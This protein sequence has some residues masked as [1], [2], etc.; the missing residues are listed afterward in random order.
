MEYGVV[1]FGGYISRGD[2]I[3]ALLQDR[4]V[5]RLISAPHGFGKSLLAHEYAQRVFAD[6]RVYWVDARSPE[7]LQELDK[8]KLYISTKTFDDDNASSTNTKGSAKA[9]SNNKKLNNKKVNSK[10][11]K[12]NSKQAENAEVKTGPGSLVIIDDIPYLDEARTQTLSDCIDA[13]LYEHTEVIVTT[14]PSHDV[15]RSAQSDRLLF[16]GQDLLI[17]EEECNAQ[18]PAHTPE[19]QMLRVKLWQQANESFLGRVPSVYF[20]TKE[21]EDQAQRCLQGFFEEK[22]PANILRSA[23]AMLILQKGKNEDLACIGAELSEEESEL[24]DD[25]YAFLGINMMQHSFDILDFPLSRLRECIDSARISDDLLSTEDTMIPKILTLLM[26][27]EEIERAG[28]ILDIFYA[29][30]QCAAW[31][32]EE[33]W[34]LLDR[35]EYILVEKLFERCP[36]K[37]FMHNLLLW[38]MRSWSAGLLGDFREA[39]FYA[40]RVLQTGTDGTL[41][42]STI[43]QIF[44]NLEQGNNT[45]KKINI[46]STED[47]DPTTVENRFAILCSYLA[48]VVFDQGGCA[49]CSKDKYG[50]DSTLTSAADFFACI[51]DTCTEDEIQLAFC[52]DKAKAKEREILIKQKKPMDEDRFRIFETLIN[53]G[54]QR[55]AS[56]LWFRLALHFLHSTNSARARVLLQD[57]A[58]LLVAKMRRKG[59]SRFSEA[60]LLCDLWECN[61]FGP[62]GM[63]AAH[64]D[65]VLLEEACRI[66]KKTGETMGVRALPVPWKPILAGNEIDAINDLSISPENVAPLSVRFFG[67]FE[68]AIGD[69]ILKD[70]TLRRKPRLLFTLIALRMGRDITR[71]EILEELWPG[72]DKVHAMD[73]FY[74]AWSCMNR[75]LNRGPYIT[76]EGEFCRMNQRFVKSDIAEFDRLT[77]TLLVSNPSKAELIDLYSQV[78]TIYSS[79]LL[80][81]E[82]TQP[83]IIQQQEYYRRLFVDTMIAGSQKAAELYDMRLSLWF[84]RQAHEHDPYNESVYY[85]LIRAEMEV[86]QRS[87]AIRTYEECRDYLR[88]SLGISPS[89][90]L[91]HLYDQLIMADPAMTAYQSNAYR[92]REAAV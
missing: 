3:S 24:L 79:G 14:I 40:R 25:D 49:I 64:R 65:A 42:S 57:C 44:N 46:P 23:F 72:F 22:L 50:V 34:D 87:S 36:R 86:G 81:T 37:I 58:C 31:L 47:L 6:G 35:G 18:H 30:E 68:L 59:I 69:H 82:S 63:K 20:N 41:D 45:G 55:F 4:D 19:A 28:S 75:I 54:M 67:G 77:R 66:L 32:S 21:S 2:L 7:F 60:L 10:N 71:Q 73:N 51:V 29:D 70:G 91:Q 74:N 52:L 80:P 11:S 62:T 83:F 78:E 33:G 84:A 17:T 88:E 9:R 48:L 76:R 56:S 16:R 27:K 43:M 53:E 26:S 15:L 90:E 1:N 8:N 39:T 61:Y 5:L 13:L 85:A 38:A 89:A 92:N 12:D